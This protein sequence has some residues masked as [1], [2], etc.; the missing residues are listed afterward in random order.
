MTASR[1]AII[2]PPRGGW[3]ATFDEEET[4]TGFYHE[5]RHGAKMIPQLVIHGEDDC[6]RFPT[7]T[8]EMVPN[9]DCLIPSEARPISDDEWQ[10]HFAR[11]EDC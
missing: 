7:R 10:R 11:D 2:K 6:S 3:Y 9:P 8:W 5:A 4:P 1:D